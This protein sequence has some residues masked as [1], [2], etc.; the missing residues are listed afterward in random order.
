MV[1]DGKAAFVGSDQK[2]A[3]AAISG[4]LNA[5]MATVSIRPIDLGKSA[6]Q[7]AVAFS[8]AARD[9]SRVDARGKATVFLAVTEDKLQSSVRAG[10]NFGR[11]LAHTGVVRSL[12]AVSMFDIQPGAAFQAQSEIKISSSWK[13]KDLRAVV[14]VQDQVTRRIVGGAETAF[15]A[16]DNQVEGTY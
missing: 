3:L 14:F 4:E 15:P 6:G 10:E 12:K 1:V 16:P 2:A 9:F 5:P 13:R 11:S 8:I 7:N